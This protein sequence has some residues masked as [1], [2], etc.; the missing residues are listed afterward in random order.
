MQKISLYLII[1]S[2]FVTGLAY[3]CVSNN[4]ALENYELNYS[5]YELIIG[6]SVQLE[7]IPTPSNA[8][9]QVKSWESSNPEIAQVFYGNVTAMSVGNCTITANLS[10]DKTLTCTITVNAI[11]AESVSI[12]ARYTTLAIGQTS[13]ISANI[14][15]SNAT[16]KN[17]TYT[18]SDNNIATINSNHEIVALTEGTVTITATAHNGVYGNI[19][20]NVV[21]DIYPSN[22]SISNNIELY[23][24]NS[25]QLICVIQPSNTTNDELVWTSSNPA[26]ATVSQT[27]VV[28]GVKSGT[29]TITVTAKNGTYATC[30]VTV[31]EIKA[32][33]IMVTN[34]SEFVNMS[35]GNTKQIQFKLL[36]Y[37]TTDTKDMVQFSSQDESIATVSSA[38]LVTIVGKGSTYVFLKLGNDVSAFVLISVF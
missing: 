19:T 21:K 27:G 28:T 32:T 4:P 12:S 17:L 23:K 8:F 25:T 33:Q 29:A 37:N 11:A 14:T 31:Q 13:T 26:V 34:S 18:S 5:S 7:A 2:I 38:G 36:P 30:I 3:V 9:L 35:V 15:P 1:F 24:N 6:E 10:N 16:Y 20:I 22:I